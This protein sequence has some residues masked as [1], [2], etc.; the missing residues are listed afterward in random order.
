M[1]HFFIL[2]FISINCFLVRMTVSDNI[3]PLDVLTLTVASNRT[4]GFERYLRSVRVYG[5]EN[6]VMILGLDKPWKGGNMKSLGG[7]Y[8]INL[9]KKALKKFKDDE[10]KIILFTDS[11]DVIFSSKLE[12]IVKKFKT[13]DARIVFGAEKFIWPDKSLAS[14]YPKV[15]H[16]EAYLNSGGFIGYASDV[17]AI[18]NDKKIDDTDDDQLY[19]TNVYL[20]ENLRK[21]NKIKLDHKCE[22]FQNL[23][24]SIGNI[25][26]KF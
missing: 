25:F 4:D 1:K 24:G 8:K 20:N 21:K 12:E 18:L 14:K 7:G 13:F 19:Y 9:L 26:V 15:Y 5:F 10:K 16:G 22:I 2:C 3:D 17:Y 11:Y 6:N 23:H